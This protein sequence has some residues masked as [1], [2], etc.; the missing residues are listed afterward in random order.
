MWTKLNLHA[1]SVYDRVFSWATIVIAY[2]VMDNAHYIMSK[3]IGLVMIMFAKVQKLFFVILILI[4]RWV[5]WGK[6][7]ETFAFVPFSKAIVAMVFQWVWCDA[8][9]SPLHEHQSKWTPKS[10]MVCL[11]FK[12][13]TWKMSNYRMWQTKAS[14]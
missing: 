12:L 13:T 3:W 11:H 1:C 4:W 14:A 8:M 7:W 10:P 2:D 9:H 6:R 5:W